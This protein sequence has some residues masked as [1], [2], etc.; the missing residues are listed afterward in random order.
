MNW[1]FIFIIICLIAI[2]GKLENLE[3]LK[4]QESDEKFELNNP[5]SEYE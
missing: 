2:A 1:Y 5:D 4:Q 3:S